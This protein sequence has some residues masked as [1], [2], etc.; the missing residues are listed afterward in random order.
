MT[1]KLYISCFR[2]MAWDGN[3][4]PVSAPM[5]PPLSEAYVEIT[6]ESIASDEFP[7]GTHFVQLK[8]E[9]DCAVAFGDEP[10]ADPEYHLIDAGERI[11][12]GVRENTR[13]AVIEVV[14]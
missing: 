10:V 12:Y 6:H 2:E 7:L 14:K 4:R 5:M 1:A 3:N 9:A 13:V 11:F 8:A